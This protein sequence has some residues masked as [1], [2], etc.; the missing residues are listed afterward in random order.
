MLGKRSN[1]RAV[2]LAMLLNLLAMSSLTDSSASLLCEQAMG[3]P[4]SVSQFSMCI[5]GWG[6]GFQLSWGSVEEPLQKV[7]TLHILF[8]FTQ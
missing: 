4:V 2:S 5:T 7:G 6:T 1:N 3:L 8:T